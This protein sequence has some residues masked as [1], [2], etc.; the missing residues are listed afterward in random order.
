[1]LG[2]V[3][4]WWLGHKSCKLKCML[5]LLCIFVDCVFQSLQIQKLM[6]IEFDINKILKRNYIILHYTHTHKDIISTFVN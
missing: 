1:M 2:L 5:E 3:A 6:F 4:F